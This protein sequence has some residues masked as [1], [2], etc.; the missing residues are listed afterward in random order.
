MK[1]LP[2][3]GLTEHVG[4]AITTRPAT[5]SRTESLNAR[6]RRDQGPRGT[7]RNPVTHPSLQT[8]T[9]VATTWFCPPIHFSPSDG[10]RLA[11]WKVAMLWSSISLRADE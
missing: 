4:Y 9:A 11:W 5:T 8:A 10:S 7:T 6:F 2:R 3:P 1:G